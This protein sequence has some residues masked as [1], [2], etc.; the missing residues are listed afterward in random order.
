[1]R[2]E[3]KD[4]TCELYAK[5]CVLKICYFSSEAILLAFGSDMTF[6]KKRYNF[7]EKVILLFSWATVMLSSCFYLVLGLT[8]LWYKILI[9][10]AH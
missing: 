3:L 4:S 8:L 10:N 7:S 1:M 9:P 2:I 6:A 5:S